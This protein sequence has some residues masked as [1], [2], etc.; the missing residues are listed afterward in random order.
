MNNIIFVSIIFFLLFIIYCFK[1]IKGNK[2][3]NNIV[4]ENDI[5]NEIKNNMNNKETFISDIYN[6]TMLKLNII[7]TTRPSI[8]IYKDENDSSPKLN[9]ITK[10]H[11]NIKIKNFS[12][13]TS[14]NFNKNNDP[15][16]LYYTDV[17]S[18]NKKC[19][20]PN[21]SN[22]QDNFKVVSLCTIPKNLL[23]I[24]N[25]SN[26]SLINDD[27]IL[28]IGYFNEIEREICE[29]IIKSQESFSNMN[30]YEFK[31]INNINEEL[32]NLKKIDI[33]VYYNT[34]T[35]PLFKEIKNKDF[36]L[37]PYIKNI[38]KDLLKY[39]FPFYRK[40]IFT[41]EKSVD[42]NLIYN[43]LQIDTIIFTKKE[44][45]SFNKNYLDLLNYF[46]EFLKINYY[47]QYFEFTEISKD[48]SLEKQDSIKEILETFENNGDNNEDNN[49]DNGMLFIINEETDIEDTLKFKS[50]SIIS[51]DDIIVYRV[52]VTEL[53]NLQ[54]VSG[55][56][57][58]FTYEMNNFQANK[59]YYVAEVE[60]DHIL[61]E[62]AK[63]FELNDEEVNII[64]N[65]PTNIELKSKTIQENNLQYG[66]NVYVIDYGLG[67]VIKRNDGDGKESLFIILEEKSNNDNDNENGLTG[68]YITVNIQQP[69]VNETIYDYEN[70]LGNTQNSNQNSNQTIYDVENTYNNIEITEWDSQCTTNEQCPFYLANK[71]TTYNE[72]GCINGYCQLPIGLTRIG[73]KKYY[74][75]INENN[76]PRCRGCDDDNINCCEEQ[77]NSDEFNGPDYIFSTNI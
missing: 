5:Q 65:Q 34:L 26:V 71:N 75:V 47:S 1:I 28:T 43:T 23:L 56:R 40:K 2:N 55:D 29:N 25:S 11:D 18:F 41:I 12:D 15:S 51:N 30:N 42:K 13:I 16:N 8:T 66:D 32:F 72:G 3:N 37:I 57:I 19:A 45:N 14:V 27:S 22:T 6:E 38:N 61:I 52:D 64:S 10:Y 9:N 60:D 58:L 54:I 67:I 36:N 21:G 59:V 48:W 68:E 77:G 4:S 76:Y 63:K 7:E 49:G 20:G 31:L 39:Y 73:Y 69:C 17:Y 33:F 62:N 24:S 46:N 50:N 74:E 35:H 44:N 70:S 53:N